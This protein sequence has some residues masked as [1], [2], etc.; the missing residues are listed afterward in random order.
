MGHQPAALIILNQPLCAMRWL[1][2]TWMATSLHICA[3]GGAN[4]LYD[5][6]GNDETRENFL[7]DRIL[8]DLDSLRNDVKVW[9][10]QHG[11]VVEKIHDQDTTDLGKCVAHVEEIE[12]KRAVLG[13][14]PDYEIVVM[15]A[16]GGRFDQTMSSVNSLFAIGGGRKVYLVCCDSIVVLLTSEFEHLIEC[17]R[18][19]EG[20]TCGLIPVGCP[21]AHMETE[22]L[23]W[24]LDHSMPSKFGGMI[25]TS[26]A[27]EV[28][29][30]EGRA[31]VKVR[32]DAPVLWSVECDLWK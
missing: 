8:G 17:D 13:L 18:S 6:C 23:K 28:G 15:G 31:V 14:D 19:I 7:P 3:D 10:T 21:V 9:Y 30:H 12:R 25:S 4:R 5:L 29:G 1:E 20:P 22:G 27:F 16:L 26:N 32:T 11:V 2:R 24:N